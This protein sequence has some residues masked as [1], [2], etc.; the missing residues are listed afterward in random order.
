MDALQDYAAREQIKDV[1]ARYCRYLDT[2]D[3]DGFAALFTEDAVLDVRQDTGSDPFHGRDAILA[4]VRQAVAN[5][6]SSH[7]V[8]TPE[9]SF[10]GPDAADVIWAMQDRVIWEPA[11][12]PIA[13]AT[14]ITGYGHYHERYVRQRGLWL[15]ASLTLT[16]LIIDFDPPPS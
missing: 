16:R 13:P 10:D 1:K 5:A 14:G 15:I 12:S 7:Q 2:R 8:H 3:W 11:K 4:T 6:K 9:I